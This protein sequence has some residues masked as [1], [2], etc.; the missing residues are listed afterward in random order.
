MAGLLEV[1]SPQPYAFNSQDISVLQQ[2]TG[3]ILSGQW[4]GGVE[5]RPAPVE[6]PKAP[7][8][9]MPAPRIESRRFEPVEA[10]AELTAFRFLPEPWRR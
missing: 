3:T 9:K 1:F 4:H 5:F 7:P 10:T 8:V 6:I 2:L